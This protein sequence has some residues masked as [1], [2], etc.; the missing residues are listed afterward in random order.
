VS[1]ERSGVFPVA[2]IAGRKTH[3][4]FRD[5]NPSAPA[6]SFS[7]F[8]T[9]APALGHTNP[10][11]KFGAMFRSVPPGRAAIH[12]RRV[13]R[14]IPDGRRDPFRTGVRC[15]THRNHGLLLPRPAGPWSSPA[16]ALR[17]VRV[18]DRPTPPGRFA[19]WYTLIART[20]L[21]SA[22][23]SPAYPLCAGDSSQGPVIRLSL[24]V[25]PS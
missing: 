13:P 8:G 12:S 20:A 3:C 16:T 17:A 4:R 22:G 21:P 18:E 15:F 9:P 23:G 10:E 7:P 14:S 25:F 24:P 19:K 11:L 1:A 6:D 2:C 5:I